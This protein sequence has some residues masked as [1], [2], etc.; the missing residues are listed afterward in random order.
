MAEFSQT[1]NLD[2]SSEENLS[3]VVGKGHQ[4]IQMGL[5]FRGEDSLI[6]TES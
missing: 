5:I 3:S 2:T 4:S 6:R 1:G